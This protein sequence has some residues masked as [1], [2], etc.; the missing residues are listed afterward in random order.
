[1]AVWLRRLVRGLSAGLAAFLLVGFGLA[2]DPFWPAPVAALLTMVVFAF[3]DRPAMKWCA[4]L[5]AD[6]AWWT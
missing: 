6:L 5:L 1:M 4:D 3:A 2:F